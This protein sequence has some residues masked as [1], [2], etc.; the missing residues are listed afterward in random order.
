MCLLQDK[1][2]EEESSKLKETYKTVEKKVAEVYFLLLL[3][4]IL[5]SSPILSCATFQL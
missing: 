5:H 3:F 1:V 4:Y 2:Q